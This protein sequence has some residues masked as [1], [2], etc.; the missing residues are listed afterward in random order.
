MPPLFLTEAD[1][2]ELLPMADALERV[3]ASFVAQRE[4]QAINRSRQ[5]I[6]LSG[7]SFHFMAA[8]LL[9]QGWFG[10]KTYTVTKEG[11][12]FIV[13]LF[14]AKRGE[15]L[16]VIEADHLGRIRTGAATGAATKYMARADAC[17]VGLFGAGRQGR[18]QLAAV[19][20][21]RK[22]EAVRVYNRDAERRRAFC[23]EM[24]Q[25]LKVSVEPADHAEA[26]A[27]FGDI[28][29]TA[30]SSHEPVFAGEW[31][32]PGTHVNA[33]GANAA[34]RR[35]LD[36]T[37]ITRSAVI[38]VDS[39]EQAK[40]EAGDLIQGLGP[41]HKSWENVIEMNKVVG[42]EQR[43]RNSDDEITL[44]KSTGI[45]IW[46]IAAAGFIYQRALKRGK[47][48]ELPATRA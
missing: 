30:T 7:A 14:D 9:E 5:R 1:V 26:A 38:A 41:A 16:A 20:A 22:I 25:A 40:I 48:V 19:A 23:R 42:G 15:L 32:A 6:F 33:I 27:R 4:G 34:N 37:A 39:L 17:R 2:Q 11:F 3:E 8:A 44:F 29:I 31:I 28:L 10:T 13:L 21:V 45:A 46:D 36:S 12:R 18:A 24:E 35:E 43:G 47:G